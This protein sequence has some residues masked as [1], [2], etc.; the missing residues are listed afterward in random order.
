MNKSYWSKSYWSKVVVVVFFV[1]MQI[2]AAE[3]KAQTS[4]N[5]LYKQTSEMADMMIQYDAD[6]GSVTRFYASSSSQENRFSRPDAGG[7]Y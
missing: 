1:F 2:G 3:L 5:S 7:G 6:K 4:K